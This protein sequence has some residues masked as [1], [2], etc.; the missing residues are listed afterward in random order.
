MHAIGALLAECGFEISD[1]GAVGTKNLNYIRAKP[2]G[3]APAE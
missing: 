2:K 1:A 3:S